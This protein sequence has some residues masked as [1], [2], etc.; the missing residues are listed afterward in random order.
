[1]RPSTASSPRWPSTE[2]IGAEISA[3]G[4]IVI[5]DEISCSVKDDDDERAHSEIIAT[6][7][8]RPIPRAQV[9]DWEN[10]R[11]DAGARKLGVSAAPAMQIAYSRQMWLRAKRDLGEDEM[12]RRL[13]FDARAAGL[14]TRLQ[15]DRHGLSFPSRW[16][17][18]IGTPRRRRWGPPP[19]P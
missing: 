6:V 8:D 15:A 3:R 12:L 18:P 17:G 13:R 1:M 7:D 2:G 14:T 16:R 11:I 10:R 4:H 5:A 19:V 9:R